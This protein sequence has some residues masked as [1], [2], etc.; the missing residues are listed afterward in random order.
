MG[1]PSVRV[2]TNVCSYQS[3]TWRTAGLGPSER[4]ASSLKRIE[5]HSLRK[6]PLPCDND[7]SGLFS[8]KITG[9]IDAWP[10]GW[11]VDLGDI[12]NRVAA[13]HQYRRASALFHGT[14]TSLKQWRENIVDDPTFARFDLDRHRHPV[15]DRNV[16]IPGR[17]LALF[18]RYGNRKNQ[19]L[20]S[21][22][23]SGKRTAR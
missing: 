9:T 15:G 18:E 23:A 8:S 14:R 22:R 19:V 1:A 21:L 5:V 3:V 17:D 6:L 20:N 16:S 11:E 13:N 7:R 2:G 12:P 10:L 4:D